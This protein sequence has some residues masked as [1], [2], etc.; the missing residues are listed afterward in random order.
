[1][2]NSRLLKVTKDVF[3]EAYLM[4]EGLSR[5][6]NQEILT[7]AIQKAHDRAWEFDN[8]DKWEVK[9]VRKTDTVINNWYQYVFTLGERVVRI[10][11]E[12]IIYDQGFACALWGEKHWISEGQG[13]LKA[14]EYHLREMVIADD[15]IQYLADNM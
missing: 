8:L 2:T 10:D 7:K 5:M 14:W 12:R 6:T 11:A 4:K 1:M 15:P 13:E 3:D 9:A